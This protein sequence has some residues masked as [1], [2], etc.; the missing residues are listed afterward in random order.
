MEAVATLGSMQPQVLSA[1]AL[2]DGD[3]QVGDFQHSAGRDGDPAQLLMQQAQTVLKAFLDVNHHT[4][5]SKLTSHRLQQEHFTLPLT[6][7]SC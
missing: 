3:L 5:Q 2:P 6:V 1:D 7:D 4:L